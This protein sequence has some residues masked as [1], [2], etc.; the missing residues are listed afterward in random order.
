[1][2]RQCLAHAKRLVVKIGSSLVASRERGLRLDQIARLAK[3]IAHLK[4]QGREVVVVS[5]G[6]ILAGREKLGLRSS[7]LSLPLK[8]AS[9]AAG[10]SLLIAAYEQAFRER[11][12][13]I[14][15]VL[16]T[17]QDLANRRRFLNARHT[18]T[19]LLRLH[20]IPIINEND[21]VSV[22]EIRFGDN[23]T[24]AG[25]VAHLV[26]ADLFIIL[27]NVEGLFSQDPRFH[28]TAQLISEVQSITPAI[29]QCA[30]PAPCE[31]GTGG[32][33]TKV[34]AAK[35]AAQF[36]VPTLLLHGETPELMIHALKGHQVGTFF[37]PQ[38]RRLPSRKQWIAF[39][40][41]PKG[42]LRLDDGAVAA[43][44]YRGKSLLPSGI[45]A[46]HGDFLQ[47]DP[48]TCAD[49]TGKDFAK[50][51]VNYPAETLLKIKGRKTAELQREGLL[52]EYEEVI[53]RDNLVLL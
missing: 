53:H 21:T 40:L 15:Q 10:Q 9:A 43:L 18:L 50:G 36:G 46:V 17:H 20:V 33:I 30:G 32:M 28:K 25:E 22:E 45:V 29:E 24:L 3:D 51:L 6:A 42:Q 44:K 39:T 12:H 26:D 48:V 41:R 35:R 1:M 27:S 52:N 5:S 38:Q 37:F 4:T 47:G 23:D 7:G 19:T 31:D 16:L 34:Q 13:T 2:R 14:A 11:G 49:T 8:Q